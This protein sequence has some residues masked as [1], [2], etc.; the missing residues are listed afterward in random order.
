MKTIFLIILILIAGLAIS[1][2][3][4]DPAKFSD[5]NDA[6]KKLLDDVMAARANMS[7]CGLVPESESCKKTNYE[8]VYRE[9]VRK[10][11]ANPNVLLA[12]ATSAAQNYDAFR[13][14]PKSAPQASQI[15]DQQN[16]ELLRVIVFQNQRIIELL[17]QLV[18]K[19]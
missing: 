13:L 14:A 17:D 1:G 11:V 2:Q 12:I 15:A 6:E 16:A 3:S 7:G 18:K 5:L 19:K 9:A 8:Q 10:A 4:T